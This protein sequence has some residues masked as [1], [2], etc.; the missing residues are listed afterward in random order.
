M[1]RVVI[2]KGQLGVS[3]GVSWETT[4]EPGREVGPPAGS[5]WGVG[6]GEDRQA[7]AQMSY[8]SRGLVLG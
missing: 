5:P 7:E 3:G 1:E 8:G 2:W 4:K 6:G